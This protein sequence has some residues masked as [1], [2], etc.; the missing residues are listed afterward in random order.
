M[1]LAQI[2]RRE[3]AF[4]KVDD[5]GFDHGFF[6]PLGALAEDIHHAP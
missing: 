4:A 2:G 1:V 3:A 6:S 5:G